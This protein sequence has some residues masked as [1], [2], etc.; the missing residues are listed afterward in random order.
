MPSL[1]SWVFFSFVITFH[2]RLCVWYYVGTTY[3]EMFLLFASWTYTKTTEEISFCKC[4]R[5]VFLGV[6]HMVY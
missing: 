1:T 3:S 4:I 2:I 5:L 6:S